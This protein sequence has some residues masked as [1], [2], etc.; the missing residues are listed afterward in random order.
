[1]VGKGRH[2][3][4]EESEASINKQINIELS[5]NYQ[6]LA[7]V[8]VAL[9]FDF[10]FSTSPDKQPSLFDLGRLLRS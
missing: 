6:Y 3:Y 1:M 2:N 5:A 9:T 4:H 7:M 8:R 10:P